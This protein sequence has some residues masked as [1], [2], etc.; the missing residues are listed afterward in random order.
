MVTEDN[1]TLDFNHSLAGKD[2]NFK[3]KVVKI[4]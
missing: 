1:L 4:E 3:L 2:L